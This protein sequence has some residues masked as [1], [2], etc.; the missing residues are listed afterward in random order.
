MQEQV[1][2]ETLVPLFVPPLSV[3]LLRA[4]QLKGEL[5]GESEVLEIRD[6]AI[7]RM[8]RADVARK[9]EESRGY[10]DLEPEHAWEDWRALR[11]SRTD[12]PKSE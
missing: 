3:L 10:A 5:L 8:V 1:D 11:A 9:M 12:T 2:L 7:C 4:E 6:G